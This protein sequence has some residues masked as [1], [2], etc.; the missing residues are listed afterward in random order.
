MAR[1]A[2]LAARKTLFQSVSKCAHRDIMNKPERIHPHDLHKVLRSRL[3]KDSTSRNTRICKEDIQPAIF[4]HRL[5]HDLLN[6]CLISSIKFPSMNLHLRIQLLKFLLMGLQQVVVVIAHEYRP[7]A[8]LRKLMDCG[9]PDSHCRIGSCDN[10]HF[11]GDS[12]V[13]TRIRLI[14]SI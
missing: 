13:S 5:L 11:A 1:A 3:R 9:S 8:I 6:L 2:C 4:V 7:R 12:T 10:H 14:L